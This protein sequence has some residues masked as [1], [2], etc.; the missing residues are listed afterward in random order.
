MQSRECQKDNWKAV[1]KTTCSAQATIREN[2]KE[3]P[4]EKE[5]SKKVTRWINAWARAIYR[6]VPTALDLVNHEWGCHDTHRYV[7]LRS[8]LIMRTEPTGLDEDCKLFRV[9]K[10]PTPPDPPTIT[11]FYH[12]LWM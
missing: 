12:R 7:S 10:P 2:L 5:W 3:T 4:E 8:S 11:Q 9:R 6:C 1:H